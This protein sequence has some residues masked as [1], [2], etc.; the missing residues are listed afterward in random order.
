MLCDQSTYKK[1]TKDPALTL[2]RIV[3]KLLLS[4]SKNLEAQLERLL[5]S[6]YYQKSIRDI[7]RIYT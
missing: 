6:M 4:P 2:E 1:L 5:P 3:N 7:Y